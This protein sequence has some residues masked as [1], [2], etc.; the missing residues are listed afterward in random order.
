MQGSRAWSLA[1]NLKMGVSSMQLDTDTIHSHRQWRKAPPVWELSG[2]AQT[3]PPLP[4]PCLS[5][6]ARAHVTPAAT[7]RPT[8]APETEGAPTSTQDGNSA[9]AVSEGWH[10]IWESPPLGLP[11]ADIK[12]LK[13]DSERGL[14]HK[15]VT[16]VDKHRATRKK[17]VLKDRMW[18]HP[19]EPPGVARAG[20]PSADAFFSQPRLFLETSRRVGLQSP[21]SEERVSRTDAG[22]RLPLPLRESG[23]R[24]QGA[25]YRPLT[26]MGH[27]HNGA[28]NSGPLRDVAS[29][30]DPET[31]RRQAGDLPPEGPDGGEHHDQARSTRPAGLSARSLGLHFQ[32][33]P[34]RRKLPCPRL[35]RK[36]F[37]I[38][39]TD[40]IEDY[41]TQIMST[42]GRV[43]KYDSTKKICKKLSGE[44]R[45]TAEWCTNMGNELGQ[46]LT[47][48]KTCE[49]SLEMMRPMAEGLM[50]SCAI[51]GVS[52]ERHRDVERR[53]GG[54]QRSRP[55]G[56]E[57]PSLLVSP[58]PPGEEFFGE[59]EEVNYQPPIPAGNEMICLEYLFAQST[60]AFSIPDH[61]AQT[62]AT[63]Q[64][65]DDE[66]AEEEDDDYNTDRKGNRLA[67]LRTQLQIT[68]QAVA[69]EL[70]PCAE[71][72]DSLYS[73]RWGKA[74]F[75]RTNGD[76][77]SASLVQKLK[78]SK[79][80]SAAHLL[81]FR[82]HHLMYC[83]IKQLWLY[84]G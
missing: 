32:R 4:P 73:S 28:A 19:P 39:E 8:D 5:L 50:D 14:F 24:L 29:C 58:D 30:L 55:E 53:P 80:Y 72:F 21:L 37:L 12:W 2:Q 1:L 10:R 51:P 79:R 25:L 18:F 61:Y 74:L 17:Q 76:L 34:P 11:S 38:A 22:G 57:A 48:V 6:C 56:A 47:S 54:G 42:F 84:P 3:Q 77:A 44:G 75:G 49:E 33:A 26:R 16:Y 9:Q 78:F 15:E 69:A 31:R 36:A 40:N 27:D 70:D 63:I 45:G 82:K 60:D 13:E 81:D 59:V 46:S 41:R 7:G 23:Q 35:L 20:I 43:L 66:E 71:N 68:D 52:A 67:P 65:T 64:G 62:R 83:V